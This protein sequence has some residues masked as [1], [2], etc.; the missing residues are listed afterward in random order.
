M[1]RK[2][3]FSTLRDVLRSACGRPVV[4][5]GAGNIAAKTARLMGGTLAFIVD[6]NPNLWGTEQL[7]VSV[8][9]P[10]D[11]CDLTQLPF[12]LICTTSFSDVAAQLP[13]L[14][15][16]MGRDFLVSPVLNDLRIIGE[17]ESLKTGLLITSGLPPTKAALRGGGVYEVTVD[18]SW[19]V[20]K[21][22]AGSC[23]GLVRYKDGFLLV[24][25]ELGLV[26]MDRDYKVVRNVPLPSASRGHGVAHSEELERFYVACSYL[27]SVL[28]FDGTFNAVGEIRISNKLSRERSPSHHLNDVCVV[29][30]SLYVSMFSATGNWKRDIFDGVVLEYDLITEALIGT[31]IRDLWM[32]HNVDFM[33]GSLVVCD[34][35]RGALLKGNAQ[36]IGQFPGFTRGLASDGVFHYIGQ[37]RNRN[38]SRYMGLAKNISIDTSVIVFD[39]ETKVSRSLFLP[40]EI[41]EI[42]AITVL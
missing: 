38:F 32:P 24:D 22:H 28:V 41:S 3:G 21:V 4:L 7:G 27:D 39:E 23:H 14:G 15:Y 13:G 36:P 25:D 5:F 30:T 1:D 34:S 11:L 10:N 37:S 9:P 26:E 16:E 33:D 2:F 20:R 35:L 12:V 29:G 17:L 31:V 40:S 42:H 19:S 8:R 18:G 6:N